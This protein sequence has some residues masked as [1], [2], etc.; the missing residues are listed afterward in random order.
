[1]DEMELTINFGKRLP[2]YEA[3]QEF[4]HTKRAE[5]LSRLTVKSYKS[6]LEQFMDYVGRE[7]NFAKISVG[8]IR[9]YLGSR[10]DVS[11]KTLYNY[12]TALSSLWSWAVSDG[13]VRENIVR[14][15]KTPKYSSPRIVPFSRAEINRLVDSTRYLR[16]RAMLMILIDCGIRASELI[17]LDID[18]W[19]NG[20][21][22]VFGKGSKER[23]VPIS[24][25]TEKVIYK[26]LSTREISVDGLEGGNAMFVGFAY[27]HDRLEYSGLLSIMQR[28]GEYSGVRD[29]H[30]HR[31]RHTFA[32]NY[33][34]NGGDI[35]PLQKILGH[36]TLDMVKTYLDIVR[37][38][39]SI[40][41][42]RAS[43]VM[44]WLLGID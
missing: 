17:G 2:L 8:D 16:N 6:I 18:D 36:T 12:H 37:A 40:A 27:P 15:V 29:V 19:D 32:I 35:Y 5:R 25:P 1:M 33:L 21:L 30:C 34:R 4:I 42:A 13:L 11:A 26:Y 10:D 43:P 23:L 41:H 14:S 44:N 7:K 31:F 39:I 22:K 20:I 3:C 9:E 28:L 38:D 24:E